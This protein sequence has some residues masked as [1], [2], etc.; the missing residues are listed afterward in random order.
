MGVMYVVLAN[1]RLLVKCYDSKMVKL[2]SNLYYRVYSMQLTNKKNI[3]IYGLTALRSAKG[4]ANTM[5]T[6]NF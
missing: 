4:G 6:L 5:G 3:Y 2:P 1:K